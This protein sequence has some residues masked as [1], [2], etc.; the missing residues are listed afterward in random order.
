MQEVLFLGMNIIP[1]YGIAGFLDYTILNSVEFWT[2]EN[3]AS[4][5]STK[6]IEK[7]GQK[8][9]QTMRNDMGGRTQI[10]A[11]SSAAGPISTTTMFQANG[12]DILN[13]T[14]TYAD[15]RVESRTV[16]IDE[17]GTFVMSGSDGTRTAD[18]AVV[19]ARLEALLATRAA[20]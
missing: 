8:V 16:T 3:P 6:V 7:N 17:R 12:S 13:S 4:S 11:V 10:I 15:G 18:G 2:G 5:A 14:T 9:V 20:Y 1:V 19:S